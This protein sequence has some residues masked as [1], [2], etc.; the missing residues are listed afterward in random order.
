MVWRRPAVCCQRI[1]DS[2]DQSQFRE[3]EAQ[4]KATIIARANARRKKKEEGEVSGPEEFEELLTRNALRAVGRHIL[5]KR[6]P[7]K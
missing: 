7:G 6:T 1:T 4:L 3:R 2:Q 5:D